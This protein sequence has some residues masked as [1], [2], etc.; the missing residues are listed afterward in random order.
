MSKWLPVDAIGASAGSLLGGFEQMHRTLVRASNDNRVMLSRIQTAAI[1]FILFLLCLSTFLIFRPLMQGLKMAHANMVIAANKLEK[2]AYFD[3]DTNLPNEQSL[4]RKGELTNLSGGV[5]IVLIN[6]PVVISQIAG[7]ENKGEFFRLFAERVQRIFGGS[8]ICARTGDNEFAVV[9]DKDNG[10]H[11]LIDWETARKQVAMGYSVNNKIVSP[12]V[13]FGISDLNSNSL[14]DMLNNA[15]LAILCG[16]KE[17][18]VCLYDPSIRERSEEENLMIEEIRRG[19]IADEFVPYYQIKVDAN[20]GKPCGLEALCRWKR[21]DG[22]IAS[23][24]LFIPVAE[25]SGLIVDITWGLLRQICRDFAVWQSANALP[26]PVAFNASTGCMRDPDFVER[27]CSMAEPITDSYRPL[28]LEVTENVAIADDNDFYS[29]V[30]A[31]I[32]EQGFHVAMDDFG[33][34]Y[35]SLSSIVD[36]EVDVIKID[37]S[38]VHGMAKD[39]ASRTIVETVINIARVLE[40][41]CVAEGV[42]TQTEAQLLK[43][44]GCDQLQGFHFYKPSPFLQVSES[45]DG[46]AGVSKVA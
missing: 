7:L 28:E 18:G 12:E 43:Q 13:T 21:S 2:Q 19:L 24:G 14:G 46:W 37:R 31:R 6:N 10:R 34:G 15:R 3:S 38:F 39:Q 42:E 4:V 36:L 25:S 26:G 40:A 11:E 32:R 33:T 23:P 8:G 20:T 22:T 29:E 41:S 5:L 30:L 45:L 9:F 35:A 27:L 44:M 1:V 17:A 16:K